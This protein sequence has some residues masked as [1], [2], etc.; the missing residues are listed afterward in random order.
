[1]RMKIIPDDRVRDRRGY[2]YNR[3]KIKS[4]TNLTATCTLRKGMHDSCIFFS[5]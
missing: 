3:N 1:M 2:V 4:A 5:E